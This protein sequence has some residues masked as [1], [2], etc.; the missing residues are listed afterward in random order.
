M[1][2]CAGGNRFRQMVLH[3]M[4]R[5]ALLLAIAGV[6]G[7]TAVEA[8]R[9]RHKIYRVKPRKPSPPP[10]SIDPPRKTVRT[11]RLDENGNP[12]PTFEQRWGMK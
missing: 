4:T 3:A 12:H 2:R 5:R 7:S 11:I 1:L 9:R 6:F 10:G 8:A